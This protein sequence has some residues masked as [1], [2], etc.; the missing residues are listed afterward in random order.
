MR[1]TSLI[2]VTRLHSSIFSLSSIAP[3]HSTPASFNKCKDDGAPQQLSKTH[4]RFSV[5]HKRADAKNALKDLLLNGKATNVRDKDNHEY[6]KNS[7]KCKPQ[8][9]SSGKGKHSKRWPKSKHL[10]Y[11]DEEELPEK[12][13]TANFGGQQSFTWSF[14][15]WESTKCQNSTAGFE[16]KDEL[17]SEKYRGRFLNESDIEEDEVNDVDQ[18]SNR[19][20]L[21]LPSSGPLCLDD[22]KRAFHESALKWHPDKHCG[23]AQAAAA[24]KFKLC[25][26]AYNHLLDALKSS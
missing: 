25:V 16:W 14:N 10:P 19:I 20:A 17:K 24:E 12:I 22:V 11:G 4:I 9:S 18:H 7:G 1:R 6:S 2:M 21:G 26:D 13:F 15:T 5:R 23:L 8:R 3:Y